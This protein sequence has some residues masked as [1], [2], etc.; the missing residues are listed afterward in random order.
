MA[1]IYQCA[2][3]PEFTNYTTK[4]GKSV[5]STVLEGGTPRFRA[6]VLNPA[7]EVT[8]EWFVDSFGY[9]YLRAFYNTG[10]LCGSLPFTINLY[11][12]KDT[13]T[14]HNAYFIP[15]TFTVAAVEAGPYYTIDATLAV[16]PIVPTASFD[17]NLLNL[18]TTWGPN[19]L[20]QE[21]FLNTIVNI[22]MPLAMG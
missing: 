5:V 10:T 2:I 22:E 4:D 17:T 9:E 1:T 13:L 3:T 19:F 16:T 14:T 12:D 11:M 7:T 21:D 6:D 8:V 18:Y 20:T 15:G